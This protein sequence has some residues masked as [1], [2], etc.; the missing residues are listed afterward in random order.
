M[1]TNQAKDIERT[2]DQVF[3]KCAGSLPYNGT[4][5]TLQSHLS[6][7]YADHIR[8]TAH[9]ESIASWYETL[10]KLRTKLPF[11]LTPKVIGNN[12]EWLDNIEKSYGP[13]WLKP[14]YEEWTT[15]MET[16][17]R[18]VKIWTDGANISKWMQTWKDA[19]K[20]L[21]GT[22]A[23]YNAKQKKLLSSYL[24]ENGITGDYR[25]NLMKT[26]A[27]SQNGGSNCGFPVSFG[28]IDRIVQMK[29][30]TVTFY[31]K[32]NETMVEFRKK[33]KE[34]QAQYTK[35]LQSYQW[36]GGIAWA[37]KNLKNT[38]AP[39]PDVNTQSIINDST[40]NQD[41]DYIKQT[42]NNLYDTLK[43]KSSSDFTDKASLDS[44]K[45]INQQVYEVNKKLEEMEKYSLYMCNSQDK[46][47]TAECI[48]K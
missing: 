18:I 48:M 31:K 47:K 30:E 36:E 41:L 34:A 22:D 28:G 39:V 43:A 5:T 16:W 14:C 2:V 46:S 7:I 3:E 10:A 13:K 6:E 35:S 40:Y 42:T 8:F 20:L 29:D 12:P 21:M 11:T 25:D 37:F 1:L 45:A 26:L 17:K 33:S 27:C 38:F 4:T 24:S 23:N 44:L 9:F 15:M 32:V 19:Y